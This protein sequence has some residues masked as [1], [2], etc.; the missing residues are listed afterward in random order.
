MTNWRRDRERERDIRDIE[1]LVVYLAEAIESL[2]ERFEIR[3]SELDSTVASLQ[4]TV[5]SLGTDVTA[6]ITDLEAKIAAGEDVSANVAA[7]K[8][9]GTQLQS[10]DTQVVQADPNSAVN[11]APA[12]PAAPADPAAPPVV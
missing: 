7:L 8:E 9:L 10:I 4:T 3:M 5:Q 12:A 2:H 11:Q 1:S 6:E